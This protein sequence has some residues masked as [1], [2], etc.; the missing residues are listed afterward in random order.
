MPDFTNSSA[1]CY[2]EN[3]WGLLE[4]CVFPDLAAGLGGS[5]ALFGLLLGAGIVVP[6]WLADPEG[7]LA[8]PSVLLILVGGGL[9][10]M[11]PAGMR[12]AA[13]TLIILGVT[14]AI[15]VIAKR[16]VLNP[17]VRV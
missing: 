8:A 17:G 9:L 2:V 11:L 7:R 5:D 3:P 12:G 4:S 16:Y 6:M 13:W 14:A 10:Q 1:A 15:G